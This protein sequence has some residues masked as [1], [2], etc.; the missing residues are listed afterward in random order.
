MSEGIRSK[1]DLLEAQR[2][3]GPE[4]LVVVMYYAD[5]C[6]RPEALL[7]K[8]KYMSLQST[9][10]GLVDARGRHALQRTGA[11]GGECLLGCAHKLRRA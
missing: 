6:V 4:K 8:G 9:F 3:A 10:L 11:Y 7:S 1:E 5:W 2:K